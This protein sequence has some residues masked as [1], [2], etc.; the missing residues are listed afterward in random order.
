LFGARRG[1]GGFLSFLNGGL[2]FLSLGLQIAN[3]FRGGKKEPPPLLP[4]QSPASVDLEV[5]NTDSILAGFPLV[6]RGQRGEIRAGE[7]ST[8]ASPA[9]QVVVNV[10]AMDSQ[11]FMDRSDDIARAVR[12]AMLHMHPINDVVGEI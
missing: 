8:A 6:S 4:S 10:S 7:R 1:G 12:D 3:L 9:P 2:G 5:A 11:S